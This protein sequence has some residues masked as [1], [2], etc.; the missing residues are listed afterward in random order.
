MW[1]IF[2]CIKFSLY[3]TVENI[4]ALLFTAKLFNSRVM[5]NPLIRQMK[6]LAHNNND[7]NNK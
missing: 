3:I 2:F 7:N 6:V 1:F 5:Q 4:T